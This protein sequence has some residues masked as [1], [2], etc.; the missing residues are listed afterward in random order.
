LLYKLLI[1]KN[2]RWNIK[3]QTTPVRIP[4]DYID[5]V[6]KSIFQEKDRREGKS[7]CEFCES[8]QNTQHRVL[9]EKCRILLT[10]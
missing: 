9:C 10:D 5:F 2:N 8:N 4:D 7:T 3:G 1:M 6:I